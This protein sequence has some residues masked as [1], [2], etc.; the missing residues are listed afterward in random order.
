[1]TRDIQHQWHMLTNYCIH[2][3]LAAWQQKDSVDYI[4]CHRYENVIPISHL[5]SYARMN[6]VLRTS[7]KDYD[8]AA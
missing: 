7:T 4:P 3:G 8:P 5:R 1:M 2:C 6:D